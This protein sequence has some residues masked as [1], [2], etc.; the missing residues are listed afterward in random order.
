MSILFDPYKIGK[1]EVKN[2]FVRS[3]TLENLAKDTGEVT[4]E[5]V[6]LYRTLAKGEIGLIISGYMY[7]HPLGRGYKYQTGIHNDK[8]IPSLKKITHAIHEDDGKVAFQI[9]HAGMQTFTR[10]TGGPLLCPSGEILNPTSFEYS[11]EMTEEEIENSIDAFVKAAKRAVEA[12]ADAIQLH[13]AHGY[14]INQ[15]LSP[16]YNRR[17]DE[18]GGSDEQRIRYLKEIIF[19]IKKII[20]SNVPLIIK[21]NT[22]DYT[23]TEGI[24]PQLGM[25]YTERLIKLGIDAIEISCGSGFALFNMSRGDIP[26]K[27]FVQAVPDY[28]KV[29]V[30]NI[31]QDMVGKF[32]LEEGYNLNAAKIIKP[33]MKDVPLL[34]VGGLRSKTL[35]EELI[36][37][38]YTDFISMSRPFIREPFLVKNFREEN[39]YIIKE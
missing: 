31:Y 3:A 32:V 21:L 12:G 22:N 5:L 15:F 37:S 6:N 4:E 18:W 24:T 25:N 20:P 27:E 8:L 23:P 38:K 19:R 34:L 26:V 36:R 17:E 16:F 28:L 11:R 2:R 33:K 13:A 35:M 10:L 1:I 9:A 29:T 14:L 30:E 7:V 39:G